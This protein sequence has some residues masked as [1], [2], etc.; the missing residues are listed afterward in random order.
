MT[1]PVVSE[2]EMRAL[3]PAYEVEDQYLQRIRKKILIRTLIVTALFCVRLLMLIVSPEF[4]VRTFFPDDAT[5]GEEYIDQ[6]ILFRMAVLIPF[7]FIYYISFWKN[8]YFRTVTVLSLIITC[9]ILWSD[10]E[11]HL[12]ALAGEPLLGVLTALAIRLV[13]LYLLAL[14]YMDVRR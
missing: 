7:A 9:S 3:L 5:K 1:T 10:A 6:I 2:E 11:L 4:H 8:L 12:A 14:N 13:I